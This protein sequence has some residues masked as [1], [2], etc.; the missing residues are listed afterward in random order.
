MRK[1]CGSTSLAVFA[2]AVAFLAFRGSA[3]LAQDGQADVGPGAAN[4]Y[5]LMAAGGWGEAQNTAIRRLGG[6]IE[7][8]HAGSGI[9]IASSIDP[10]FLRAAMKGSA[11]TRGARDMTVQ[12]QQPGDPQLL[13]ESSVASAVT[14]GDDAFIDL[15]WNLTAIEAAG[16]WSAGYDGAGVRVAV[17]DGGLCATHP[18][19]AANIDVARSASFVPGFTY[20]QDTGGA[21][22]FRHACHVAGIIAAVDNTIGT[23]GVAPAA[24]IIGCKALHG[25]SGSF[26][27]VIQAI[28]YAADPMD[29]GGGGANII[30]MSLGATIARGGGNTGVAALAAAMNQAVAYAT[31]RGALVVCAAGG[32]A[33]DLDHS[34][35]T[36][37]LPAQSSGAIAVS[38]TAPVGFAVGWPGGATNFRDPAAY[39]NYGRSAIWVSAPGGDSAFPG[40]ATCSIPP[41]TAP[42]WVFDLVLSPGNVAGGYAFAGGTSMATAHVSGVAAL[43]AQKHPG[44]SAGNLGAVL[45]N[46]A[47][48]EGEVGVDPFHGHGFL[49]AR[50]AVEASVSE[51]AANAGKLKTGA[52]PPMAELVIGPSGNGLAPLIWFDLPAAGEA[53][54]ELFD[55]AGRRVATLFDGQAPRGRTTLDWE[56]RASDGKALRPGACFAR[57]TA[58]EAHAARRLVLLGP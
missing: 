26:G 9:G 8:S 56:G 55:V 38:A 3:V 48:D 44:I 11:F 25:G 1:S 36:I 10:D 31:A 5:V 12:W 33:L 51:A 4:R 42:C 54:V 30:N 45:A 34:G 24:T 47:D 20:D 18:D 7:F 35:S 46:T 57:L 53:R 15:L 58:G 2:G 16:A 50:R 37:V 52:A 49:N 6:T 27:A 29:E 23:I 14:P 21:T 28:L 39:T 17:I 40:S 41:V 43:V 19:L 32:G 22:A 13:D